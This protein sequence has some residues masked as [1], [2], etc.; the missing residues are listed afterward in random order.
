[1]F[2]IFSCPIGCILGLDGKVCIGNKLTFGVILEE[3]ED[4]KSENKSLVA[5]E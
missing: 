2:I 3:E 5:F 1:M 4:V